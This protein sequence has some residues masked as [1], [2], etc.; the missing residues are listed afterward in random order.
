MGTGQREGMAPLILG[1]STLSQSI[2]PVPEFTSSTAS[3]AAV[4][5]QGFQPISVHRIQKPVLA[6]N[7]LDAEVLA[8]NTCHR[9]K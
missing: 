2:G 6:P 7:I 4:N 9:E 3:I 5:L 1:V 8:P